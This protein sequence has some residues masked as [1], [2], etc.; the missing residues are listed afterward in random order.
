MIKPLLAAAFLA[1]TIVSQSDTALAKATGDLRK[2]TDGV[3]LEVT[4]RLTQSNVSGVK[5]PVAL[6]D[7]SMLEDLGMTRI[8]TS[9]DWTNGIQSFEGPLVSDLLERLGAS[10]TT[11]MATAANDYTVEIPVS[12]FLRYP[13]ILAMEM[14]GE[15]LTL[16][17]KGP[18]W[19]VYPRDQYPELDDPLVNGR[20]IWQL[21]RL[22][23][24]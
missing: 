14:N 23:I 16:R 13:I 18:I 4:G 10:G 15:R 8:K 5:D 1:A 24:R 12:D 9:T 7:R 11:I 19:I 22:E 6:L 17:D 20:W 2:P 3:L 21:K